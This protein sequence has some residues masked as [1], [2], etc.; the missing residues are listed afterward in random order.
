MIV[1]DIG[2][3]SII[4]ASCRGGAF[5]TPVRFARSGVADPAD[6]GGWLESVVTGE[7]EVALASVVPEDT[8]TI[9]TWFE[10]RGICPWRVDPLVQGLMAHHLLTPETT[11]VDR[12][13]AARAAF[14]RIGGAAIVVDCG[15]AVTVDVVDAS[16]CFLGGVILPG[17]RLWSEALACNTAQLPRV[18][19]TKSMAGPIGRST[20]EA[21]AGGL[22]YGLSGAVANLIEAQGR[23]FES[24]PPI[25]LTG[26]DASWMAERLSRPVTQCPH[27]VLEGIVLLARAGREAAGG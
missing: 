7:K 5:D 8:V 20:V 11:G 25:I 9:C 19:Q 13:C 24:V 1:I 22:D 21:L 15:T 14:E 6:L 2:N 27:L 23:S 17:P 3:S 12:L 10:A 26:G 4:L 16:G 18:D